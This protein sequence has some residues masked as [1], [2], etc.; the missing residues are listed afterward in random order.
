MKKIILIFLLLVAAL[1]FVASLGSA[2]EDKNNIVIFTLDWIAA[3]ILWLVVY[4]NF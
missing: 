1:S 2:A 4:I 3:V